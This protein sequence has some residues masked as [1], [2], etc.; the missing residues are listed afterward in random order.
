[1]YAALKAGQ[2]FIELR[3]VSEHN[4]R[5]IGNRVSGKNKAYGTKPKLEPEFGAVEGI[6]S[7]LSSRLVN[8]RLGIIHNHPLHKRL[9]SGQARLYQKTFPQDAIVEHKNWNVLING[10]IRREIAVIEVTAT[11]PPGAFTFISGK[12]SR[13]GSHI[14]SWAH[15]F[16]IAMATIPLGFGR[17]GDA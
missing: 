2:D 7:C 16:I 12:N 3:P 17:K 10:S 15:F 14:E 1:L 4:S 6:E 8:D 13:D 11:Q 9:K 5:R